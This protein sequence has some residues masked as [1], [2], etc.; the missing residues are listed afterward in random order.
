[1]P[2]TNDLEAENAA[3]RAQRLE[4]QAR[5]D[6]LAAA[7]RAQR[8]EDQ[9][10]INEL[11]QERVARINEEKE[12]A[13]HAAKWLVSSAGF[14]YGTSKVIYPA[15]AT[16]L[17]FVFGSAPQRCGKSWLGLGLGSFVAAVVP[18]TDDLEAE[19]EPKGWKI[20][21]KCP[22]KNQSSGALPPSSSTIALRCTAAH[23]IDWF[24][25]Y[26]RKGDGVLQGCLFRAQQQPQNSQ[27]RARAAPDATNPM[28]RIA[29]ENAAWRAQRL[30]DQ[31]RISELER[32]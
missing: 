25:M 19:I 22:P 13:E 11:E 8:L 26:N 28:K 12:Q 4:D 29:G 5:L 17:L 32:Q 9:A 3:L 30:E 2:E 18:E 23:F 31:A 27:G 21:A 16:A 15:E 1:M 20:P 6:E 10:R 7:S 14:A 24:A